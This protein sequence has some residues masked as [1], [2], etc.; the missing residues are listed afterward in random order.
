MAHR[1]ESLT[2]SSPYVFKHLQLTAHYVIVNLQLSLLAKSVFKESYST[3][4]KIFHEFQLQ[5]YSQL[6]QGKM[7][8]LQT[9]M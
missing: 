6:I 2:P 4:M 9:Y 8:P 1:A 3:Q 7:Q 5:V